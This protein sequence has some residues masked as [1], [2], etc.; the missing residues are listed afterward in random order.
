MLNSDDLTPDEIDVLRQI[1]EPEALLR[2]SVYFAR[3]YIDFV[4][5]LLTQGRITMNEAL[6]VAGRVGVRFDE[7]AQEVPDIGEHKSI[8]QKA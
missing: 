7:L 2:L 4:D 1:A 3:P 8:L 5:T 6:Q